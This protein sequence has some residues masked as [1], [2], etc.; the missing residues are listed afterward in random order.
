MYASA[1]ICTIKNGKKLKT[2]AYKWKP[3]ASQKREFAEKM[4]NEEFA[5]STTNVNK[6]MI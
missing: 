5:I 6:K 2:M 1:Y 3:S 4:Q